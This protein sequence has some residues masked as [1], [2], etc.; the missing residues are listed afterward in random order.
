MKERRFINGTGRGGSICIALLLFILAGSGVAHAATDPDE[1]V[2]FNPTDG[3]APPADTGSARKAVLEEPAD[4][5]A[6]RGSES[7]FSAFYSPVL[8]GYALGAVFVLSVG[9]FLIRR[10]RGKGAS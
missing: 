10:Y 7:T 3:E 4:T 8:L 6:Y 5:V 2:Q 1:D 9:Y